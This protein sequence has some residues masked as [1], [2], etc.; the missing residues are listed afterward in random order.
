MSSIDS[1]DAQGLYVPGEHNLF[2]TPLGWKELHNKYGSF[3]NGMGK[4][5]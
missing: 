1:I 2:R 3:S 4:V 5:D